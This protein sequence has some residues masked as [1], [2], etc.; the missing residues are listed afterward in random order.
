VF[1]PPQVLGKGEFGKVFRANVFRPDGGGVA[2][3]AVKEPSRGALADFAAEVDIHCKVHLTKFAA[4]LRIVFIAP[5]AP[6]LDCTIGVNERVCV[7]WVGT[8]LRGA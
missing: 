8:I 1:C 4:V 6:T 7:W 3:A 2:V 5:H